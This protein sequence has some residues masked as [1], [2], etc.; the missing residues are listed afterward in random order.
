MEVT[1]V[2][3][4]AVPIIIEALKAWKTVTRTLRTFRG[5]SKEVKRV[6]DRLRV[7]RCLFDNEIETLLRSTTLTADDVQAMLDDPLDS[8]WTSPITKREIGVVLSKNANVYADLMQSILGELGSLQRKLSIFDQ[9]LLAQRQPNDK[10]KDTMI[11]LRSAMQITF[12][13]TDYEK[14][15]EAI[16]GDNA[17]LRSIR[18]YRYQPSSQQVVP[19]ELPASFSKARKAVKAL[20]EALDGS[21]SCAD[22]KHVRHAAKL[23][24]EAKV[25]EDVRLD[26][27]LACTSTG[28]PPP[29]P[30]WLYVRS[31]TSVP[32][33]PPASQVGGSVGAASLPSCASGS[34]PKRVKAGA[35]AV[36]STS[37]DLRRNVSVCK[38][39]SQCHCLTHSEECLGY[40]DSLDRLSPEPLRHLFFHQCVSKRPPTSTMTELSVQA[41][42]E[43]GLQV[44]VEHQLMTAHSVAKAVLHL[45]DTPWMADE[46]RL[47]D[48]SMFL[49]TG[50]QA[51]DALGP[52]FRCINIRAGPIADNF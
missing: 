38:S 28:S 15:I 50:Q 9:A 4:G 39:L 12:N 24:L 8:G 14:H 3:L 31:S 6:H 27:A 5:Y 34:N 40:V 18:S 13:K 49:A 29:E 44:S 37:R 35:S 41:A 43:T 47:K 10:L 30:L 36:V 20:Y 1:G 16:R 2:V 25:E 42:L 52:S 33:S 7:Q 45:F 22:V 11:R 26:L 17:D 51:G 23:C 21:W 32:A 48:I 46:W 19:F